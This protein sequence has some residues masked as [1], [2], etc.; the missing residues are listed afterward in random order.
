MIV[1]VWRIPGRCRQNAIKNDE[2]VAQMVQMILQKHL[3]DA[4]RMHRSAADLKVGLVVVMAVV[5]VV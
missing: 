4:K 1:A 2:I 3:V 5:V